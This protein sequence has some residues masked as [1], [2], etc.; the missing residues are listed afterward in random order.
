MN[1][2]IALRY[3]VDFVS[4]NTEN[5]FLNRGALDRRGRAGSRKEGGRE[6]G[7][8]GG[9][10]VRETDLSIQN[11]FSTIIILVLITIILSSLSSLIAC[12][13]FHHCGGK[14]FSD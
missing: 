8:G 14:T 2:V 6:R 11:I 5:T 12:S 3:Q 9:D 4:F 10:R 13:C 1:E 7:R